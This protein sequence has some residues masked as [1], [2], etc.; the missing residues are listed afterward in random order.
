MASS[1]GSSAPDAGVE[2][3]AGVGVGGGTGVGTGSASSGV[4][5][6]VRR[7][8]LASAEGMGLSRMVWVAGGVGRSAVPLLSAGLAGTHPQQPDSSMTR[9]SNGMSFFMELGPP[10]VFIL[11]LIY[12]IR[13]GLILQLQMCYKKQQKRA[14]NAACRRG[15]RHFSVFILFTPWKRRIPPVWPGGP[16]AF[17]PGPARPPP[18]GRGPC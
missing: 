13:W 18:R 1:A 4:G 6:G 2:V 5:A 17:Q 9:A 11:C 15:R 14:E 12:S 10:S 16:G 7:G 8:G 3:G